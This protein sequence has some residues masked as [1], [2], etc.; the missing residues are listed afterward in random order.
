MKKKIGAIIF[1][2]LLLS[3]A[4]SIPVSGEPKAQNNVGMKET[5]FKIL[6]RCYIESTVF[7]EFEPTQAQSEF[8]FVLFYH[9]G[10]NSET[11]IYS[12][13]GG[14]ILWHQN[15]RHSL[16]VVCFSGYSEKTKGASTTYGTGFFV[17]AVTL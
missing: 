11:T 9:Y 13:E 1:F 5:F 2:M 7:D 3:I 10:E 12:E 6:Q 14:D 15:G 4:I 8:G 16:F 17:I